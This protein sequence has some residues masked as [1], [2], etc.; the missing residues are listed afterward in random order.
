VLP[1]A[2]RLLLG[3]G[4]HPP[5]PRLPLLRASL[6]SHVDVRKLTRKVHSVSHSF[7]FSCWL[8]TL[9]PPPPPVRSPR[10]APHHHKQHRSSLTILNP[11]CSMSEQAR[12]IEED[13][14]Q[15]IA[16]RVQQ[17][18]HEGGY[19]YC[20]PLSPDTRCATAR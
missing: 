1:S 16:A 15:A 11:L 6:A 17:R 20:K 10:L 3:S 5:P 7:G 19:Q 18:L 8:I 13:E 9:P 4:P 12:T 2:V 14:F